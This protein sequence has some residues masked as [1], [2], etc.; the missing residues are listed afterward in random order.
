MGARGRSALTSNL[1]GKTRPL[2]KRVRII[3]RMRIASPLG[4]PALLSALAVCASV[5]PGLARED[6]SA[7]PERRPSATA[8]LDIRK[9]RVVER[10]SGPV[11]YYQTVMDD[12][13]GPMLR[14]R[15]R[16]PLETVTL[17]VEIPDALR[18]KVKRV[19]WRW[20]VHAFP[21]GGNEC[22]VGKADSAANVFITFKRGLKYY[23]LK[24]SWSTVGRKGAVCDKKR[25]LFLVRDTI[26]LESDGP[27]NFWANE[28]IDPKAEFV[29]HF[30]G[31]LEDVPD[32]VGIGILTDG[33][34][35]ESSS[36]AD[37]AEFSV[38]S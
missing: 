11:N 23:I 14:A 25:G 38:S 2:A 8:V 21:A 19:H 29:K 26:I 34:Q 10:D 18:S 35:T 6:A 4:F 7:A 1:P 27:L 12:P 22:Q 16:F 36:E 32:M 5:S 37:Y 30:G 3:G 17:G 9:F 24:Y 13:S 33:D 31:S 20:R 28:E 15:Y